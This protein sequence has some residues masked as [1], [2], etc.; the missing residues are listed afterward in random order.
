MDIA[1]R[2]AGPGFRKLSYQCTRRQLSTSALNPRWLTDLRTQL[3]TLASQHDDAAL[4]QQL[5]YLDENWLALSASREG[6][7]AG[8]WIGL[9]QLPVHW[10][11]MVRL[12]RVTI[13]H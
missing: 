10:G 4:R 8:K 7:L 3:Q 12:T 5:A 1:R 9:D 2:A 6:F 13:T 11:D